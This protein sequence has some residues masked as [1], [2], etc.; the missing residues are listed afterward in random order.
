MTA[1]F[2]ANIYL[3]YLPAHCSHG[4]QPCDNGI[5]NALKAEYRNELAKINWKMDSAPIDKVAFL[6]AYATA[7][8][9]AFISRTIRAA[10][11]TA[12]NWPIN[13]EKALSH[14]EIQVDREKRAETTKPVAQP[15]WDPESTPKTA[16]NIRQLGL[17][18]APA[19]RRLFQQA[20]KAFEH[21]EMDLVAAYNR[22]ECL[23]A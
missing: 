22:I 9:N 15:V 23:E 18:A 7:R 1:C 12:G 11:K 2:H 20:S 6:Q 16:W 14:P 10:W 5:F 4:L 17:E 13:R 21:Q 19:A 8:T 3:Y